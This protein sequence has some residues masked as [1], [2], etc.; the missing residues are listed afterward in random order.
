[1]S[2]AQLTIESIRERREALQQQLASIKAELNKLNTAEEGILALQSMA[3][4]SFMRTQDVILAAV[5]E[6]Y[7][8]TAVQ[9]Q[10]RRKFNVLAEARA[11]FSWVARNVIERPPSY[12]VLATWHGK[13]NGLDHT[14]VMYQ[15]RIADEWPAGSTERLYRDRVEE[16][17]REKLQIRKAA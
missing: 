10:S 1:M 11:T 4:G 13:P 15:V 9:F 16:I 5:C 8:I 12:P 17:V 14:T 2:S 3:M 6:V 7:E